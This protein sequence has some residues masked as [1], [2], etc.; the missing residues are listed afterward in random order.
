MPQ[1]L[2]ARQ[3]WTKTHNTVNIDRRTKWGN[4]FI[5]GRDGTREQVIEQYRNYISQ[6]PGLLA[7]LWELRG[8]DLICWCA[9]LPCHG[10]ILLALA[11]KDE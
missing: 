2:N 9:P 4:P 1:V 10:D 6:Q 7:D 11:N 5:M 8:K 3:F